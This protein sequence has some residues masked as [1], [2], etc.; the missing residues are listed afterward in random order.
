[1]QKIVQGSHDAKGLRIGIVVSRWNRDITESLRRGAERALIACG[2]DMGD[3]TV[4]EVPGA[5]EIPIAC[6]LVASQKSLDAIVALGCVVKGETAHFEYVAGAAMEGIREV[7]L[8][9]DLPITCGILTTYTLEQALDRAGDDENNKG[10][11]AALTAIE[12]ANLRKSL[13]T[14]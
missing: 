8:K 9:F 13:L 5:F 11:E 12:M 3:I 4:V 7:A 6:S 2:A 1:M 10:S 14:H